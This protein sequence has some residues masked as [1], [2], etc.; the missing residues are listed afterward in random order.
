[1]AGREPSG[2]ENSHKGETVKVAIRNDV[3]ET[4]ITEEMAAVTFSTG[5]RGFR[6]N[7]KVGQNG[8]RYQVTV[9]AVEIGSKPAGAPKPKK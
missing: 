8:A 6:A 5:S 7:F 1:M 2:S 4:L 9:N 3:G